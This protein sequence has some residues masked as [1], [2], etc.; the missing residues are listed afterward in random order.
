MRN[1][2]VLSA[3]LFLFAAQAKAQHEIDIA[4]TQPVQPAGET[5]LTTQ[6]SRNG[7]VI[8]T[9]PPSTLTY[10]DGAV[11]A[12]NTYT[13]SLVNFDTNNVPS[14]P[15]PS[16]SAT[17]PAD[18]P[19]PPPPPV[20]TIT[21]T[22]APPSIQFP[23]AVAG[24]SIPCLPLAVDDDGVGPLPV[25]V[26]S[27]G[28]IVISP[29]AGSTRFTPNVCP[30]VTLA[31]GTYTGAIVIRNSAPNPSGNTAKNSPLNVPVSLTVTAPPTQSMTQTCSW[32]NSTTWRCDTKVVNFS[33]GQ[34][35]KNNTTSG[36]LSVTTNGSKP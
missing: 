21:M 15:S 4:W 35:L 25:T 28:W 12:G 24:A 32:P 14:A 29:S 26:T 27:P 6:I 2:T 20:A 18:A 9:V 31:A 13:Y 8:A 5:I 3:I 22:A 16:V 1:I 11:S 10:S 23:T 17:V 30:V 34:A 33:K 36:T 7:T 19:P